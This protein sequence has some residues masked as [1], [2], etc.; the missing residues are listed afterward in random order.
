MFFFLQQKIIHQ[1]FVE[2]VHSALRVVAI[3]TQD[4]ELERFLAGSPR[5][6]V[7]KLQADQSTKKT[8]SGSGAKGVISLH[9]SG[10]G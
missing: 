9:V 4:G 6:A 8:K 3:P 5:E 10:C 2:N 1:H 7:K